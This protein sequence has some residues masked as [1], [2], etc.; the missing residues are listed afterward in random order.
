[1]DPPPYS[2]SSLNKTFSD[3]GNLSLR[4]E[5]SGD[6]LIIGL[7]FGTTYSGIG[8]AFSNDPEKI[9]IIDSFPGGDRLAPKAPTTIQ[10]EA[11]S[12]TSFK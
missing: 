3:F 2:E 5:V 7:D 4:G 9:H 10:Y 1:M 6:R 8:Y 12:K 11:G